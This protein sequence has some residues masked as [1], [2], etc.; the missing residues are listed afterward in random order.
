MNDRAAVGYVIAYGPSGEG[1]GASDYRQRITKDYLVMMRGLDEGRI[2]TIN[3]GPYKNKNESF[4]EFWVAPQGAT[5]PQPKK[6]KNDAATFRGRYSEFETWDISGWGEATGPSIG[7]PNLAGFIEVLKLQ[8]ELRAFLVAFNGEESAPGTWRRVA[9]R[10]VTSLKGGGIAA[11]RVRVIFGGYKKEPKIEFWA[12]SPDALPP[13]KDAGSERKPERPMQIGSFDRY[14]LKYPDEAKVV[15][16]GFAD[17]LK[18]D[19]S[20]TAC[21]V[22]RL[23]MPRDNET[24]E[25]L[26]PD[27]DEPPDIDL[28]KLVET[29]KRDLKKEFGIGDN[30][31]VVLVVPPQEAWDIGAIE[32]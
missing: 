19:E 7:N 11:D 9:D 2:K 15:F 4:V 30:R 5:E 12:L 13:A 16:K 31:L 20:L 3:G 28:M 8:P 29:W 1:S 10:E 21:L 32:P 27:P 14:Y 26:R 23:D 22:V 18:A 6:F 24:G 25:T 17:V